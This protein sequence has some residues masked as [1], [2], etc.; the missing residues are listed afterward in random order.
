MELSEILS[1][2]EPEKTEAE[3][4]TETP[5]KTEE[6]VEEKPQSR[7]K[8]HLAKEFEA[9]GRDPATGQFVQKEEAK[10][11]KAEVKTEV[12]AEVKAEPK[13]E[14]FTE[15][16]RAFLRGLE[17]ERKKR[18]ELERQLQAL[19][20]PEKKEEKTFWDDPEGKLNAHTQQV[21]QIAL[22]T[23]LQTSEVIARSRHAD[24]DEKIQVFAQ[25]LEQTPGLH[26]QWLS[27]PDPAEFA[28]RAG[29]ARA[30][31]TAA[32]DMEKWR[33]QVR[34]EERKKI[35]AEFKAKQD[36]LEKQ[37]KELPSSLSDVKGAVKQHQPVFT[38]PIP[39]ED[40]L[41]P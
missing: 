40:I 39:M 8:A 3:V 37:R 16:E 13:K 27:S 14:E 11:E 17:E 15:K 20:K 7:R 32:G 1:D 12:K 29:S 28:Y 4:V 35:E 19:Q 34:T 26:A 33:E 30:E 21:Q 9:Q 25:I 6:V 41:K 24:F 38:G 31:L 23:K 5:E 18:Q 10:E 22:Q 36:E 2:K